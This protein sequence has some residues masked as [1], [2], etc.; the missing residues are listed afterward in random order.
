M[1]RVNSQSRRTFL[2]AGATVA[3][4]AVVR[5]RISFSAFEK[6]PA[7]IAPLSQFAY[8]DVELLDGPLRQQFHTNHVFYRGLK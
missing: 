4:A 2:K 7:V 6:A 3:G 1:T 5:P 8:E